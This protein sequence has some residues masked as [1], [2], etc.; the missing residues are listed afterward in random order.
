MKLSCCMFTSLLSQLFLNKTGRKK[1]KKTTKW[2]NGQEPGQVTEEEIQFA[3][4]YEKMS[5]LFYKKSKTTMSYNFSPVKLMVKKL[6][7]II[8]S[9]DG[10]EG[11]HVCY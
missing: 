4:K 7:N 9:G 1:K 2:R 8:W 11:S 5:N 3:F 10:E 6:E